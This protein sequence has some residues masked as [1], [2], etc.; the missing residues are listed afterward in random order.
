MGNNKE[1]PKDIRCPLCGQTGTFV[2]Y[3][4]LFKYERNSCYFQCSTCNYSTP[5]AE[6]LD[7]ALAEL[8]KSYNFVGH[9]HLNRAS[10]PN[11][12]I[13][14]VKEFQDCFEKEQSSLV[15]LI[16][17]RRALIEEEIKELFTAL[18][19]LKSEYTRDLLYETHPISRKQAKIDILDAIGDSI[20]VLI[21]TA[22]VLGL[23]LNTAMQRIHDSNMSKLGADGRPVY[24]PN[25]KV[26]KGP[27]YFKPELNDLVGE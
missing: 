15:S 3:R 5:P 14:N 20:V 19:A 1:F 11:I 7:D 16:Y 6:S 2:Y 27:H 12:W 21:G 9:D 4:N 13:E 17:L 26:A 10:R 24:Y 8:N 22:N 25:G 18:T 23:D